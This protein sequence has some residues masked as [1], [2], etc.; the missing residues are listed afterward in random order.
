MISSRLMQ[1][2]LFCSFLML[3]VSHTGLDCLCRAPPSCPAG[4]R[5]GFTPAGGAKTSVRNPESVLSN[6]SG[7]WIGSKS[8]SSF[9]LRHYQEIIFRFCKRDFRLF[10]KRCVKGNDCLWKQTESIVCSDS[11]AGLM[12]MC[13]DRSLFR[14]GHAQLLY[15]CLEHLTAEN[16]T[17]TQLS[18]TTDTRNHV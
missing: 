11:C 2:S 4:C 1:M 10:Y 8:D 14:V 15:W 9:L 7:H 13:T 3:V 18:H 17:S 6:S 12:L 16:H 5:V